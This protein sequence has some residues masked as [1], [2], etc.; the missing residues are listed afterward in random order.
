MQASAIK[1]ARGCI[2]R[3]VTEGDMD[4]PCVAGTTDCF[5]PSGA[6]G[7]LSRSD[8]AYQP[9]FGSRTGWDFATGL[10]SI[11]AANLVAAWPR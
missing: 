9:A 3:D 2:F 7:V 11:D 5:A 1:S 10:G 6:T 8:S 4:V